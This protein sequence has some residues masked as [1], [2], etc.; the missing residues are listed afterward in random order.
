MR[1][2]LCALTLA[3]LPAT[4]IAEVPPAVAALTAQTFLLDP[5]HAIVVF[6]VDH[7]GFSQFI[8]TFDRVSGSLDLD[9]ADPA[10]A[11]LAVSID[12]ESLDLPAPPEGF[13]E[14]LMNETWFNAAAAPH[15]TFVSERIVMTGETTAEVEGTLTLRGVSQPLTLSAKLNGGWNGEP[16]E[17]WARIG[18]SATGE[19][20]RSAYGMGFG[21]PTPD[22]PWGVGDTVT[23][24]IETEWTGER[25]R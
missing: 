18:F 15:I 1:C 13:H 8:A 21:V 10:S 3:S 11:R 23:L 12:T 5:T 6:S 2:L 9:P 24:R 14:T 4:A 25:V 19:L 16:F 20:S 22:F 17:P 7:L